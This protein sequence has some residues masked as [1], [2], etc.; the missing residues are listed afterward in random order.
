NEQFDR[1]NNKNEQFD[2]ENNKNEQFDRENNKNEQFDR[3]N[4]KNEQFDRENNKNEQFDRENNGEIGN[5]S[6]GLCNP[7]T[8]PT[9]TQNVKVSAEVQQILDQKEYFDQKELSD[10]AEK[11][12]KISG[13]VE[14]YENT[15][16]QFIDAYCEFQNN[17]QVLQTNITNLENLYQEEAN[18]KLR[19]QQAYD[20]LK[21]KNDEAYKT[22]ESEH[23]KN[24]KQIKNLLNENSSLRAESAQFQSALGNARNVRWDDEDVNNSVN[25]NSDIKT[26]QT[27]LREFTQLKGGAYSLK[28][29]S[30]KQL[31]AKYKSK[32]NIEHK[33]SISVALQRLTIE[34]ILD[35][36]DKYV[37]A[38]T[39][40]ITEDF[41]LERQ[42]LTSNETF[43]KIIED[44]V[45]TRAGNDETIRITGI[46]IS[47]AIYAMLGNHGFEKKDHQF[48]ASTK[49]Q[50]LT[51]LQTYRLIKLP[52][53][54]KEQEDRA[55]EI[56]LSVIRILK[57]RLL[58]QEPPAIFQWFENGDKLDE[59][60]M[61]WV[62]TGEDE[63][64][65]V[66][67]ICAFP[68][69]CDSKTRQSY[70]KA[71]VSI[72]NKSE[73]KKE[74]FLERIGNRISL[75]SGN[76]QALSGI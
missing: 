33:L 1:E 47:Q 65:M 51:A 66:V 17:N 34:T 46:K 14:L 75:G 37:R 76:I 22:W 56:T 52:E 6:A 27:S 32:G 53:K 44:F 58:A 40:V 69:I 21:S 62:S 18:E 35:E 10:L 68:A 8:H 73:E 60:L 26:L 29:Q 38:S 2:R 57:F 42:L 23:L 41:S 55:E 50:L 43:T 31:F 39:K 9:T 24:Q 7:Q 67:D 70:I 59:A 20:E 71:K 15:K 19:I 13:L 11:D 4:N 48:V 49:H 5:A 16:A 54:Q 3:E 63:S 74:S 30:I 28:E 72:C 25:L 45:I 64:N 36:Y 12:Q 61:E